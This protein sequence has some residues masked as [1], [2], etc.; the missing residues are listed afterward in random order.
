M[1]SITS[2]EIVLYSVNFTVLELLPV[3]H[4]RPVVFIF[5]FN[6]EF[7]I[8]FNIIFFSLMFLHSSDI[9]LCQAP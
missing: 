6:I 7:L 2:L 3:C 1:S 4:R 5:S 9:D 8:Q